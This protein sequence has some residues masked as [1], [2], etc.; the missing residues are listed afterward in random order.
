[1]SEV[2]NIIRCQ[3]QPAALRRRARILEVIE[4]K[5]SW[6]LFMLSR[7]I[8]QCGGRGFSSRYVSRGRYERQPGNEVAGKDLSRR[9]QE[10]MK[11]ISRGIIQLEEMRRFRTVN[12]LTDLNRNPGIFQRN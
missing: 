5:I 1:M 8:T 11:T 3:E 10:G 2:K 12:D 4:G 9:Q 7:H 6:V